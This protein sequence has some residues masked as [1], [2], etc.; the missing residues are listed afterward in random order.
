[1]NYFTGDGLNR[2][3]PE[4]VDGHAA[5]TAGDEMI[6]AGVIFVCSDGQ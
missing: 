4:Y 3:A 5:I 1:M 6:N 2:R